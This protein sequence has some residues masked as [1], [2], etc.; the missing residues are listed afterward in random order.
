MALATQK[1]TCDGCGEKIEHEDIHY[2][3]QAFRIIG[4]ERVRRDN[5]AHDQAVREHQREY[6]KAM[7][8]HGPL[9]M[10]DP[11]QRELLPPPPEPPDYGD[12]RQ[13][14]RHYHEQC[15]KKLVG[16]EK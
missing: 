12:E 8:E 7:E 10:S 4:P 5:A 1:A 14:E 11:E 6:D 3:M 9:D 15:F 2:L 13:P 16:E